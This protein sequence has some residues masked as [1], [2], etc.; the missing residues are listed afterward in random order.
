[1]KAKLSGRDKAKTARNIRWAFCAIHDMNKAGCL[2]RENVSIGSI[3]GTKAGGK[4]SVDVMI[5]Q[6]DFG[7]F[8][9]H[10]FAVENGVDDHVVRQLQ[11]IASNHKEFRQCVGFKNSSEMPNQQWKAGWKNS[12]LELLQILEDPQTQKCVAPRSSPRSL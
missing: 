10:K 2:N 1:M 4:G 5:A 3:R 11:T 8:L 9:T 6:L 12:D 7:E